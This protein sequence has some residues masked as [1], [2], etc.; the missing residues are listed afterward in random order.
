[1]SLSIRRRLE[2]IL[3][4]SSDPDIEECKHGK[5]RRKPKTLGRF[6]G[7][8]DV[9]DDIPRGGLGRNRHRN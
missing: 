1:M 4:S 6:L 2:R 3:E 5:G 7:P 9:I 8:D